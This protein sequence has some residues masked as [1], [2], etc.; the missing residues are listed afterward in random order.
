MSP[1]L[2]GWTDGHVPSPQPRRWRWGAL[3]TAQGSHLPILTQLSIGHIP[4]SHLA[5]DCSFH[6]A[7]KNE[8]EMPGQDQGHRLGHL[9]IHG[10]PQ[11]WQGAGDTPTLCSGL[12]S[13]SP[14]SPVPQSSAPAR[15]EGFYLWCQRPALCPQP[16]S[17]RS[18]GLGGLVFN[19]HPQREKPPAHR[20]P[21]SPLSTAPLGTSSRV[22]SEMP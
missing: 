18:G 7:W 20:H 3:S 9:C 12:L 16:P 14:A 11:P 10:C 4:I 17:G 13:T 15:T 2:K 19:T 22:V 21:R 6:G 5:W 8:D 1:S